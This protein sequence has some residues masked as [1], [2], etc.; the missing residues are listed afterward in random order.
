MDPRS[1]LVSAPTVIVVAGTAGWQWWVYGPFVVNRFCRWSVAIAAKKREDRGFDSP[2]GYHV[3]ITLRRAIY[4]NS[5][6]EWFRHVRSDRRT[7]VRLDGHRPFMAVR[8]EDSWESVF[9]GN[10]ESSGARN[11]A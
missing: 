3:E 11:V 6:F 5:L 2:P 8:L 1:F 4:W 10:P 7:P 9:E